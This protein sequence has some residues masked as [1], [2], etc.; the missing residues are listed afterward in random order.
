MKSYVKLFIISAF[1][2]FT[3]CATINKIDNSQEQ[4]TQYNSPVTGSINIKKSSTGKST[5]KKVKIRKSIKQKPKIKIEKPAL[6]KP[7]EVERVC[8]DKQG[9]AHNCNYK[10]PKPY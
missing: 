10:I 2:Y 4:V 6:K 5:D 1:I 9:K 3:G 8:F 7:K